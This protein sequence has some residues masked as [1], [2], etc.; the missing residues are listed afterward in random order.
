MNNIN[1]KQKL[2]LVLGGFLLSFVFLEAILSLYSN[3]YSKY[4]LPQYNFDQITSNTYNILCLGDSFTYGIGAGFEN[5]YP[6]QLEAILNQNSTKKKFRVFNLGVPS[7]NSSQVLHKLKEAVLNNIKPDLVIILVS[8]NDFWNIEYAL[9]KYNLEFLN[10][11]HKIWL[12]KSRLLKF[13]NILFANI[14]KDASLLKSNESSHALEVKLAKARNFK[15]NEEYDKAIYILS[16]EFC[17]Y[18]ENDLVQA[19]LTDAC[20]QQNEIEASI[21]CYSSLLRSFPE[22][23]YLR[24]QLSNSYRHQAGLFFLTMQFTKTIASYKKAY[25]LNPQDEKIKLGI[26]STVFL[27]SMREEKNGKEI[28]NSNILDNKFKNNLSFTNSMARKYIS[29]K[30]AIDNFK[31]FVTIC[32]QNKIKLI[33]SGYPF[34]T[35]DTMKKTANVYAIPLVDHKKEFDKLLELYPFEKIFISKNDTHCTK[36][37]YRVMAKNIAAMIL[38]IQS[39]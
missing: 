20:I 3:F 7:S 1:I 34:G 37:G 22:S 19:E 16:K 39:E 12:S 5:S 15:L 30:T 18:P 9:C 21:Q 23:A 28:F 17:L 6:A 32:S 31:Q 14:K 8:Q 26:Y 29:Q 13:F 36:F 10:M 38:K 35:P 33:F 25:F 11:K 2:L 24:I 4:Q 27:K